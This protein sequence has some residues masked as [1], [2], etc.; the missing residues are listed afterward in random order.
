MPYDRPP[1]SAGDLRA[2]PLGF[3]IKNVYGATVY[4]TAAAAVAGAVDATTALQ[5]AMDD[6]NAA[7]GG[8]VLIPGWIWLAT[9]VSIPSFVT[10]QGLGRD[11]SGIVCSN[12]SS[13]IPI[14]L[15][16][17]GPAGNTT[18]TAQVNTGAR[19]AA[20][21]S[22][23]GFVVGDWMMLYDSTGTTVNRGAFI[24]RVA[25]ITSNTVTM[26]EAAPSTYLTASAVVYRWT[27][28][29]FIRNVT[30]SDMTIQTPT[31]NCLDAT[32]RNNGAVQVSYARDLIVD[33]VCFRGIA[34][35]G[36]SFHYT[37]GVNGGRD[38]RIEHCHW[39]NCGDQNTTPSQQTIN[40]SFF[41]A[42]Q[43]Q[44]LGNQFHR[45]GG[46]ANMS[47]TQTS[48]VVCNN[49]VI[50]GMADWSGNTPAGLAIDNGGRGIKFEQGNAQF[51][52]CGNQVHDA[53]FDGLRASDS[54][55][56]LFE[57]NLVFNAHD[58]PLFAQNC[59]DISFIGNVVTFPNIAASGTWH[60]IFCLT[61]TMVQIVGNKVTNSQMGIRLDQ[62]TDALI[63]SNFI[64]TTSGI[65]IA[66]VNATG[67]ST[68][69]LI[70]GNLIRAATTNGI[71][72]SG[73]GGAGMVFGNISNIANSFAA[74]DILVPD[75]AAPPTGTGTKSNWVI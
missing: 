67:T 30:I 36:A 63:A 7:G 39:Y 40:L 56:G 1:S 37:L 41:G 6:C 24:T 58:I 17:G 70:T 27:D 71:S 73:S 49:N 5:K 64:N 55:N 43:A 61:C 54:T 57:A 47:F 16:G 38:V 10:L 3:D 14:N 4:A 26:E 42:T 31:G 22:A 15:L 13:T 32:T 53:G 23:T 21:T 66:V 50:G 60:A 19:T 25:S 9:S 28:A 45:S 46:S 74:N 65:A 2:L 52:C 59:N 68:R 35:D 20:L 44:V 11:I 69:Y 8:I 75:A 72:T 33:N 18:L 12:G 62:V 34:G 48:H 29:G 51:V